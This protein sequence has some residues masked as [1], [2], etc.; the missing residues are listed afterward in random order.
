M[1]QEIKIGGM[2]KLFWIYFGVFS[3]LFDLFF[4]SLL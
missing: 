1:I 2:Y 3:L 4:Q